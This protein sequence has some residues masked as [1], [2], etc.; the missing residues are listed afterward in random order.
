[1]E[2]PGRAVSQK[3]MPFISIAGVAAV[4]PANDSFKVFLYVKSFIALALLKSAL[5]GGLV[6]CEKVGT[7]TA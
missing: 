2:E 4:S 7:S 5:K 6:E 1:M 3:I